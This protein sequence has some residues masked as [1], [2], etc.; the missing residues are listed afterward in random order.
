MLPPFVF[1]CCFSN[2][3]SALLRCAVFLCVL[4]RLQSLST[5][6]QPLL[7]LQRSSLQ[8]PVLFS[9][10]LG[11]D[12]LLSMLYQ[13]GLASVSKCKYKVRQLPCP[14]YL[15][16]EAQLLE[17]TASR[18]SLFVVVYRPPKYNKTFIHEFADLLGSVIFK[19]D[20]VLIVGDF[21]IHICCNDDPLAKD[22]L[23]L[24]DSFNL[25]QWVNQ[26][27]HA[28]GHTL[29]LFFFFHVA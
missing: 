23:A 12:I 21:N 6:A 13:Y 28:R 14:S 25:V 11:I 27:T 4:F 29:D 2:L 9:A 18:T 24:T 1:S 26:P 20:C 8:C 22:F 5:V 3:L 16:D 19:Y 15:S 17:M 10:S 7:M